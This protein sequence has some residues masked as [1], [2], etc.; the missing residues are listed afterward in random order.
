M[1]R[2]TAGGVLSM[3]QLVGALSVLVVAVLGVCWFS[4]RR[5]TAVIPKVLLRSRILNW[6]ILLAMIGGW[7]FFAFVVFSVAN[8]KSPSTPGTGEGLAYAII[9]AAVYLIWLGFGSLVA[10]TWAW[11]SI[12]GGMESAPRKL[13]IAQLVFA[14]PGVLTG[15]VVAAWIS[16]Q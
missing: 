9:L 12:R 1:I 13:N 14:A 10:T 3:Q 8:S 16:A 4:P 2:S 6:L 15:I 11:L 7:S 5:A